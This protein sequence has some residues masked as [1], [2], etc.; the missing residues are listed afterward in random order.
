M[1]GKPPKFLEITSC[2]KITTLANLSI[3]L[4]IMSQEEFMPIPFPEGDEASVAYDLLQCN[5]PLCS[6]WNAIRSCIKKIIWDIG[7]T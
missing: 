4:K 6:S 2:T 1:Q 7:S 5:N 3:T